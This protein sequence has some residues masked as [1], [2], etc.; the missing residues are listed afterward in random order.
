MAE[1]T[2][3]PSCPAKGLCV[4]NKLHRNRRFEIFLERIASAFHGRTKRISD[5]Y[6]NASG[7]SDDR[8]IVAALTSVLLNPSNSYNLLIFTFCCLSGSW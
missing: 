1:V 4:Y 5:R 8:S 3:F 6:I 7:N 2:Y